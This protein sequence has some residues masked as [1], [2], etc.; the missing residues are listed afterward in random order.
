MRVSRADVL[1]QQLVRVEPERAVRTQGGLGGNSLVSTVVYTKVVLVL[2]CSV[3]H[4]TAEWPGVGV[5][6]QMLEILG[7]EKESL[8]AVFT[9]VRLL[10]TCTTDL[11]RVTDGYSPVFV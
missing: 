9:P 5:H 10:F 2:V 4:R 1:P 3:T 7:A 11:T 8:G 6:W